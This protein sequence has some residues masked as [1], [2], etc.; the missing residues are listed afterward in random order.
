[1]IASRPK[2]PR[3]KNP[4]RYRGATLTTGR[5]EVLIA[6]TVVTVLLAALAVVILPWPLSTAV[7]A[8]IV[9]AGALIVLLDNRHEDNAGR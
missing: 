8:A 3:P 7:A 6:V 5:I 2:N 1:M 9:A 4:R